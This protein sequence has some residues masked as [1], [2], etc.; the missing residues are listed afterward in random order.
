MAQR[1]QRVP[2]CAVQQL[3]LTHHLLLQVLGE[4]EQIPGRHKGQQLQRVRL[5]V[6]AVGE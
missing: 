6:A 3:Q 2:L 4:P 5:Q 1:A